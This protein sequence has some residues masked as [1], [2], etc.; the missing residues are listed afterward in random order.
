MLSLWMLQANGN[1][2]VPAM[3]GEEKIAEGVVRGLC[4]QEATEPSSSGQN[5]WVPMPGF[6]L[7]MRM[8]ST[9]V[10]VRD[11]NGM[12]FISAWRTLNHMASTEEA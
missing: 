10:V 6:C 1:M 12:V 5:G 7:N 9:R 4:S 2:E 8:M 3:K 11:M